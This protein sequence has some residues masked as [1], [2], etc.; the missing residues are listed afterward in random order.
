MPGS[1]V[2]SHTDPDDLPSAVRATDARIDITGAGAFTSELTRVELHR[3]WL[4][5][6][7]TSLPL[8]A[9]SEN[10]T[11][12][13]SVFLLAHADHAPITVGGMRVRPG[14]IVVESPGFACHLRAA[15]ELT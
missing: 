7:R 1:I 12:R 14:E 3:L 2:L 13:A 10:T 9:H 4:Q 8:V 5:R 11:T 15:E 6:C